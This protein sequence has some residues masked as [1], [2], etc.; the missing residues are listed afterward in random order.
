M[1]F[2]CHLKTCVHYIFFLFFKNG[3]R[4]SKQRLSLIQSINFKITC[5]QKSKQNASKFNLNTTRNFHWVKDTITAREHHSPSYQFCHDAAHWPD[6]HWN[7]QPFDTTSV[8][9]K[10]QQRWNFE[11]AQPEL[12][13]GYCIYTWLSR[14]RYQPCSALLWAQLTF[15]C[16]LSSGSM[17]DR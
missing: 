8:I 15:H 12:G 7:K 9:H 1:H 14:C 2:L 17:A 13:I 6:V 5:L 4:S 10:P 11:I 3:L 16:N